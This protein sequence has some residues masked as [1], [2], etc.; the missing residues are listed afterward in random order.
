M[1]DIYDLMADRNFDWNVNEANA[2]LGQAERKRFM[3]RYGSYRRGE[4]QAPNP[5]PPPQPFHQ[6]KGD[7]NW[8]IKTR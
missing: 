3:Q 4:P 5:D 2:S 7:H 1:A 8:D 6:G